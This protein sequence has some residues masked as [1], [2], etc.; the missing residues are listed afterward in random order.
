MFYFIIPSQCKASKFKF[1]G[2]FFYKNIILTF[3]FL[4]DFGFD[5]ILVSFGHF[6][7]LSFKKNF[8]LTFLFS[9]DILQL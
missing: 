9:V 2:T 8:S 7:E 5:P 4:Q 3:L 1:D 6:R